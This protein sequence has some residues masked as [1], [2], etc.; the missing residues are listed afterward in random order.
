MR[1]H[2]LYLSV[3]ILAVMAVTIGAGSEALRAQGQVKERDHLRLDRYHKRLNQVG[4]NHSKASALIG[5]KVRGLNSDDNIGSIDDL[6]IGHD[7][8]VAYVAVS[9]GGLMGLGDK[10][11]AVPFD[12][13]EWVNTDED[14]FARIDVTEKSLKQKKGFDHDKWPTEADRSFTSSS[15]RRQAAW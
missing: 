3:M 8:N 5:M 10:L 11:F 4:P 9:F 15:L 2:N 6:V 12:S 7:G 14:D 13:I 1:R